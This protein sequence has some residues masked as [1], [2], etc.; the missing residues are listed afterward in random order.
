[1]APTPGNHSQK[2]RQSGRNVRINVAGRDAPGEGA[3]RTT[4][5]G[6]G[7]AGRR[8]RR[9]HVLRAIHRSEAR[10]G[11]IRR[12]P[13]CRTTAIRRRRN[14]RMI[15]A[16]HFIV[17]FLIASGAARVSRR[18]DFDGQ[19]PVVRCGFGA[20]VSALRPAAAIPSTSSGFDTRSSG[21]RKTSR[22]APRS[23]TARPSRPPTPPR[24]QVFRTDLPHRRYEPRQHGQ[25]QDRHRHP[26]HN[27]GCRIGLIQRAQPSARLGISASPWSTARRTESS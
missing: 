26:H 3:G 6:R 2:Q 8:R 19:L 17:L 22:S 21:F 27:F 7:T 24:P 4:A 11:G 13:A 18:T 10:P 20:P 1:M 25:R 12:I 23:R 5:P 16:V 14:F 15:L 9:G